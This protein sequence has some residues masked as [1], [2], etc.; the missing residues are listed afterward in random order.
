MTEFVK[1]LIL[2]LALSGLTR[3]QNRRRKGQRDENQVIVNET[4]TLICPVE[5]MFIVDSSE[6]AKSL[7]FEQ[8][9]EFI[10]RFSNKLMQLHSTG[11]RLRLR[12][13]AMQ[14]SSTVSVEHNFR[15]W[16]DLDVFQS[17]VASMTF[18]G[19]GTYSAYA[20][21]NATKVFSR[22]T[23]SSSLRVALLLTDGMDHPRSP[24][25]VTAAAEAKQHN[26][27]VF[28]IRLSGP[29]REGSVG[30]KLRSIAS[31]P[32]QQH[33]LSLTDSHLDDR[34]FNELSMVVKSGCPQPKTCLCERGERG[35]PGGP[36]KPGKPGS[37]GAPGPKGSRG[38]PG[39]NGRPGMEGLEGMPGSKGEKGEQGECGATGKKGEQ[40]AVGPSGPRGPRGEQGA[41][42]V[43]GDQ[44]AEGASGSKGERGP[45]GATGAPGDNGIGFPG[46][47]GDKGNQ[48]RPGPP[49]PIGIGEPGMPGPAGPPGMQGSPG[50]PG[51]GLPGPKGDR[52]YEGPKGNR[53]PPGFGYKG[54]KGNTGA[55]GL[56]GLVGFPGPGIQG[57]KGDQGPVGPSGL[58]GPPG[59]GI[60][61]SKGDQ[62]FPGEPGPQGERG[63]GELGPK[64]EP[65][66][67]GAAGIPG[68]PGEDGAVGPKGE[69]GLPGL[70]GLE[71]TPGKGMPGEKGD[72]GDR[73]PRGLS[74]SPGPV[75]PAGAKGEPGSSGMM[76]LP[77]PAG[78]GLPGPKGDPGPVG[79][80]GPVGEPGVGIIGPKGN[81]G[82]TGP[83]GPP[84]MKGDGLPGPQGLPGLPGVQGE[85]GPE[86]KG[87]PGPKGDRG[88][89]GVPGPSGA[90]GIGLYGPKGSTGQPGPRGLPGPLGEGIPGPKGEPGF[91]G[92]MGPR[93]TPGDGLP[94]EKGD[95]GIPGDRGKK[96]DKGDYG[97]PGSPGPVGSPGEKG[98]PGLTSEEVIRIIREICGCGLK[99][100]ESPLEL[101]FVIDSSE[102]VGPENFELVKDFVNGLIDRMTVSREASRVGVVLYSH[103]DIVVVSLQQQ[104][105]QDD[106]KAAVRKMPYLGEGTF[107]GS[108]IHRA[109]QL[110]QASRPGVRKVA[111]VL[112]DGLADL[113]DI[114]QFEETSTEAHAEGIEVFVVGVVNK[115]DPLYEE[116]QA[117]MNVIASDPDEDHIYLID[118]F[119]TLLTLET[120][121]LSR[122][123]EHDTMAFTPN[124]PS[125]KNLP[126]AP[127]APR[128]K[129]FPEEENRQLEHHEE[130]VTVQP[131]QAPESG[132]IDE[133]QVNTELLV[134]AWNKLP[135][136][137]F[138]SPGGMGK[139][140]PG[141]T[142]VVGPQN[143]T[144][145][146]YETETTQAPFSPPPSPPLTD[147]PVSD[148]GC[149]QPLV[150]GPCREYIVRWYYD[151]EANACAQFWYGGCEGNT[152]NFETEANCRNTCVYT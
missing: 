87:L 13:A 107:T 86:G 22:E 140:G 117:E 129:K 46:P 64:G 99:C 101:V 84:G 75:G 72:R 91:Q 133:N 141:V 11:W 131:P 52:G 21:T 115:T 44:G 152:N 111:V 43:S 85:M 70:R 71:G 66:P 32:P 29:P 104:F 122:I 40:G 2:I 7:L 82:N 139:Q 38:E 147:S 59:L 63:V 93:G 69:M 60:V 16:Q 9:K 90:P 134:E 50:I 4:K 17:R 56:P 20:I 79:L 118:D 142:S 57:E 3:C 73:G 5:I 123:C 61:G 121:V 49:G 12:M 128:S 51:E 68:I 114:M 53:G 47:K 1:I 18:I 145:W 37:D 132:W 62:G 127:E 39:I 110:F 81:K 120:T 28:T 76:G 77:G 58:R 103:I 83:V 135:D 14:Y 42:G 41:R 27:R 112:T 8:Q 130:T 105:S 119:K 143:P 136:I 96:G 78:R 54:E 30:S 102:S 55:T 116:F 65:G 23:S 92:V 138:T 151:P 100:R 97:E 150:P 36:G 31:A 15:D 126:K 74:G 48:G 34:L 6:K 146:L 89:P 24:S 35:H 124:F 125:V 19:H 88:L 144:D 108:A 137:T 98:E 26:I 149:S 94:G 10:L 80:S 109:N 148:E 45:R 67:D 95:Q 106:I 25:A 33:V 113:R